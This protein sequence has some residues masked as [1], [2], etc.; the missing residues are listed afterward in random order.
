MF[1]VCKAINQHQE[2]CLSK[3]QKQ[4]KLKVLTELDGIGDTL[5]SYTPN[6][7]SRHETYLIISWILSHNY[8][9]NIIPLNSTIIVTSSLMITFSPH[10]LAQLFIISL[11]IYIKKEYG[12][13]KLIKETKR[14]RRSKLN[15]EKKKPHKY[16][17]WPFE[18]EKVI[19]NDEVTI[20]VELRG[21][22]LYI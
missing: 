14:E 10:C 2:G 21:M 18:G 1:T 8:I 15:I 4:V 7:A 3:R 11:P 19:I 6:K 13:Y 20:I 9:Y 12:K 22:M 5:S 16:H 17:T